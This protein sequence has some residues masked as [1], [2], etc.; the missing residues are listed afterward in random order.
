MLQARDLNWTTNGVEIRK[1]GSF[2]IR[3]VSPGAYTVVATVT[4]AVMPMMA[5]QPLQI[6]GGNVEGLRLA[7]QA[8]AWVHGRLRLE[9]D[10]AIGRLA[11][12]QVFLSLVPADGDDAV[13]SL[14]E[15]FSKVVRVSADGSFE[16]KNVPAGQYYV[17]F[18]GDDGASP[19]WF[20]KSVTVGSRDMTESGF[21]INGGAAVIDLVASADGSV[22]DG[23]VLN[24]KG[25]PVANAV[26]VAA[27]EARLRARAD[28][29]RK[30][31]SDQS[32]RFT[33]HG[34]TPGSYTLLAW[35]SVEGEAYYDPEFL[36]NYEGQGRALRVGEGERK[37]VQLAVAPISE[38]QP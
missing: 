4:D 32:G 26:M 30:T 20:L 1:D 38:E 13:A 15:G 14:S 5:Q 17:Q 33:L 22:I 24:A 3:D 29:F 16:W 23:V 36:R 35:E 37:S 9:S 19:D 8:G 25:D 6:T 12:S 21:S 27:P 28:R 18:S 2:E 10:G 31:A 34:I 11:P 7:P